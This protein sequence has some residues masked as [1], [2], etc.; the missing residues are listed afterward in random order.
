[1]AIT[2]YRFDLDKTYL[3]TEFET[4]KGLFRSA[5][6]SAEKKENFP[7]AD[8]L[9][10]E[11]QKNPENKLYFI[12]GS[13]E[14]MRKKLEKKLRLDGIKW[15]GLVLKPNLKNLLLGR[16][17]ALRE[18]VSYKLPALLESRANLKTPAVEILFGD[19]AESDAF[20][21]SLYADVVAGDVGYETIERILELAGAHR[22]TFKKVR[23]ALKEIRFSRDVRRILI[24]LDKKSPPRRFEKYGERVVP[25]YN[26]FQAAVILFRDNLIGI[27][28]LLVVL[29]ELI[30][31]KGYQFRMITNS[32]Q[33][34]L[35][36]GIIKYDDAIKILKDIYNESK[37]VRLLIDDDFYKQMEDL[38][39]AVGDQKYTDERAVK[40]DRIDYVKLYT[41][42]HQKERARKKGILESI[43]E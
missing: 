14:Q 31:Q 35:R 29:N 23:E 2:I 18:Q 12:S 8:V 15:E 40:R 6:E 34:L 42:E 21:Y 30:T 22:D 1:M 13:P 24:N 20:V 3:K 11:I 19:D 7:G 36:R 25:F 4:I 41:E 17:H 39:T 32:F 10:R 27:G 37:R 16:F 38:I 9:L 28:S 43:L 33:D 26:Y 5:F